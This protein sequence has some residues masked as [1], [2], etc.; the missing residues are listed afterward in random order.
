MRPTGDL[1]KGEG[2]FANCD[3]PANVPLYL[4]RGK[5]IN[6]IQYN[7]LAQNSSNCYILETN[8]SRTNFAIIGDENYGAKTNHSCYANIKPKTFKFKNTRYVLFWTIK[9]VKANSELLWTYNDK[10]SKIEIECFPFLDN[11]N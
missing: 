6:K 4:Y 1:L 3:L 10:P 9:A 11:K 5:T 7:E 8:W 2:V